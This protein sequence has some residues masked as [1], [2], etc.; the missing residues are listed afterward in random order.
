MQTCCR[1]TTAALFVMAQLGRVS[2]NG[3]SPVGNLARVPVI[4]PKLA[5][6]DDDI[7]A[8]QRHTTGFRAVD[9]I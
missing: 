7:M 2:V 8:G 6:G 5:F 9:N 4:N 1:D 3:K